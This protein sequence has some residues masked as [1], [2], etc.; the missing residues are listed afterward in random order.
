[1]IHFTSPIRRYPDLIAHRVMQNL[2]LKKKGGA[3]KN[4]A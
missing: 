4:A 3:E 1:Y 2:L